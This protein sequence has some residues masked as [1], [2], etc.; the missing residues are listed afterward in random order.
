MNKQL[1]KRMH[2]ITVLFRLASIKLKFGHLYMHR[3][4]FGFEFFVFEKK[5]MNNE[6]KSYMQ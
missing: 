1:L 2:S 3:G 4:S 6:N 5:W